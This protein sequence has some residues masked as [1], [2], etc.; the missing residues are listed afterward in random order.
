M[1]QLDQQLD[2]RVTLVVLVRRCGCPA[3][4]LS[5]QGRAQFF[6]GTFQRLQFLGRIREIR[7]VLHLLNHAAPRYDELWIGEPFEPGYSSDSWTHAGPRRLTSAI[8]SKP[9]PLVDGRL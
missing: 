7:V 2:D 1:R 9:R 3:L 6:D 4:N 5:R 8:R